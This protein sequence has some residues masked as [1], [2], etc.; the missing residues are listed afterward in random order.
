MASYEELQAQKQAALAQKQRQYWEVERAQ[1]KDRSQY[2]SERNQI[3]K[4]YNAQMSRVN[5]ETQIQKAREQLAKSSYSAA[6]KQ[7]AQRRW[8]P[9]EYNRTS[10]TELAS[11]YDAKYKAQA[12]ASRLSSAKSAQS[13]A[14]KFEEQHEK[15]IRGFE[16]KRDTVG[17][18]VQPIGKTDS[19][20][21][22]KIQVATKKRPQVYDSSFFRDNP[23]YSAPRGIEGT[24]DEQSRAAVRTFDETQKQQKELFGLVTSSGSAKEAIKI[25]QQYQ[26]DNPYVGT[27]QTYLKKGAVV[28]S[29]GV[30]IEKKLVSKTFEAEKSLAP[31]VSSPQQPTQKS[32]VSPYLTNYKPVVKSDI[33][34]YPQKPIRATGAVGSL[35]FIYGSQTPLTFNKVVQKT[36]QTFDSDIPEGEPYDVLKGFGGTLYQ[37]G[38][39]LFKT[40]PQAFYEEATVGFGAGEKRLEKDT[41]ELRTQYQ[42]PAIDSILDAEVPRGT[43]KEI[44]GSLFADAVLL[45]APIGAAKAF[46]SPVKPSISTTV[47]QSTPK[48]YALPATEYFSTYT[49]SSAMTKTKINLGKGAAKTPSQFSKTTVNLGSG[50]AKQVKRPSSF[51]STKVSLGRGLGDSPP[52]S[53]GG[54]TRIVA[55]SK[56][57]LLQ[58]Q[59]TQQKQFTQTKT[60]PK[61]TSK[62]KVELET[63]TSQAQIV[64]QKY[65]QEQQAQAK[66][67]QKKS[68]KRGA[69][70]SGGIVGLALTQQTATAQKSNLSSPSSKTQQA[71]KPTKKQPFPN[72]QK[73]KQKQ[74]QDPRY[75]LVVSGS[76]IPKQSQPSLYQNEWREKQLQKRLTQKQKE[77]PKRPRRIFLFDNDFTNP[78]SNRGKSKKKRRREFIGNAPKDSL[79][80]LYN[81]DEIIYVNGKKKKKKRKS[82]GITFNK[83][84]LKL[85]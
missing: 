77:P 75:S 9:T 69:A 46:R 65:F 25:K 21:T 52:S 41:A 36:R 45:G 79:V 37:R 6:A 15:T 73:E 7:Q 8:N 64:S 18:K 58:M 56:S 39:T 61:Q 80:G 67:R 85:F 17:T 29:Q 20:K 82:K 30:L 48:T 49:P 14:V 54:G 13:A 60:T 83:S 10:I 38:Y 78:K 47:S 1:G 44:S 68:L 81:R 24:T 62:T 59:K 23:N 40:F 32:Q 51:K 50:T 26:K 19:F 84:K 11:R 12:E 72:L 16:E 34:D 66:L 3:I 27:P 57:G 33:A 76:Q 2:E 28:E 74:T 43:K 70:V 35:G 55:D 22:D 53:G 71:K 63:K 4:N 42:K 5:R 31:I